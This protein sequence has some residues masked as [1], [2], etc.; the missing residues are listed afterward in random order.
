MKD[1]AHSLMAGK[2]QLAPSARLASGVEQD[3]EHG[4]VA[5]HAVPDQMGGH[6]QVTGAQLLRVQNR[7]SREIPPRFRAGERV[8]WIRHY[9]TGGHGLLRAKWAVSG[10]HRDGLA[11]LK[12][13]EFVYG[14]DR[15]RCR[16]RGPPVVRQRPRRRGYRRD[17]VPPHG[18]VLPRYV[19]QEKSAIFV[20]EV[21]LHRGRHV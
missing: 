16:R 7:R 5:R 18:I 6:V 13:G 3:S 15:A 11:R 10:P 19:L 1:H 21:N 4:R 2:E 8:Q 9:V 14:E 12:H 20:L 17:R